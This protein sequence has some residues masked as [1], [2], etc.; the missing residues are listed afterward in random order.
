MSTVEQGMKIADRVLDEDP[1]GSLPYEAAIV[2]LATAL[3][4]LEAELAARTD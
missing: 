2:T 4:E 1:D 3:V